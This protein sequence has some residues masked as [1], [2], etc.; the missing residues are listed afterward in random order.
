MRRAKQYP[1]FYGS[2]LPVKFSSVLLSLGMTISR[3]VAA[4]E[5]PTTDKQPAATQGEKSAPVAALSPELQAQR[6]KMVAQA[7]EYLR[8]KGQAPDGS[9][10]KQVGTGIT[11]LCLLAMMENGVS[12]DDPTVAKGLKYLEGAMQKDGSVGKDGS[13]IINYETALAIL[14]L[15]KANQ[16]GKYKQNIK[17]ADLFL[18]GNQIDA[19]EGKTEADFDFGGVGYGKGGKGDLSNTAFLVEA[20]IAAGA[21]P[22]DPAVQ[23]A[24]KFVSRCQNLESEHNTTPLA[25]KVNDGGFYYTIITDEPPQDKSFQGGLRSYGSMTYAGFKSMLYAG[26]TPDDKRVKAALDFLAK[27]YTLEQNPGLGEA[28][29]FYYYHLMS[30]A[31]QA[32]KMDTFTD[33]KGVEHNW[34]AEFI[35]EL[36][37]RQNEDGSWANKNR[38]WLENDPNLVTGYALLVLGNCK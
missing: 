3:A 10:T 22:D 31:L 35:A 26:L 23:N 5:A 9:F 30:R 6:Q 27:N 38:Q 34:R 8:T 17:Q 7:I 37:K 4:D 36:A 32:A 25:G 28:G 20:L 2:S 18:R 14:C 19:D 21:G 13:R 24:L 29:L 33:A 16:D 11:S 12:P 15:Q 1:R